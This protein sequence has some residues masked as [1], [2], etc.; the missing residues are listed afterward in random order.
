MPGSDDG[1]G[2]LIEY[3]AEADPPTLVIAT[4]HEQSLVVLKETLRSLAEP[5]SP[6]T[7]A[8]SDLKNVKL[9]GLSD[10]LLIRVTD[11]KRPWPVLEAVDG[12]T[13]TAV[14]WYGRSDDWVSRTAL[15]EG[16]GVSGEPGF[17]WLT[18]YETLDPIDV[19]ISFRSEGR[20]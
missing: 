12:E 17:Q 9:I 7:L 2:I 3:R 8:I 13:G 19:V 15:L 18:G 1:I 14:T 5:E 10:L 16:V 11:S 20:Y 6:A 4:D